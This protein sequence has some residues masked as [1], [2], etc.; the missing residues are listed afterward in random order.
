MI[1]EYMEDCIFCNI[2]NKKLPSHMMYEDA[3]YCAFLDIF[4]Q[5]KGHAL[6]IPKKHYRWVNDVPEFGEYWEVAKKVGLMIQKKL[7]SS[8]ISYVTIGNEV[9]HA[10]IHILPQST[11][12]LEG[13]HF[14]PVFKMENTEIE[15]LAH[16][17]KGSMNH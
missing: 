13:F 17:I 9:P 14:D 15:N 16:K 1:N 11:D 2:I 6:V 8:Y 3:N 7:S 12:K 4:P 5:V 10:H